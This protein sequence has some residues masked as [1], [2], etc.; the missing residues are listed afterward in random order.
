MPA[1][2]QALPSVV[3]PAL[4]GNVAIHKVWSRS[5]EPGM[6]R[7]IFPI[8]NWTFMGLAV[9]VLLPRLAVEL[10]LDL[11]I[12]DD[13][14]HLRPQTVGFIT[15][16]LFS[17]PRTE[18]SHS[19][20]STVRYSTS[21][22]SSGGIDLFHEHL[23]ADRQIGIQNHSRA[24]PSRIASGTAVVDKLG[25][26]RENFIG[27]PRL[28]GNYSNPHALNAQFPTA[29]GNHHVDLFETRICESSL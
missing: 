4:L 9:F 11:S 19:F 21:S 15:V 1:S 23:R 5:R 24:G 26:V 28:G 18:P 3:L 2:L 12:H 6:R 29:I 27:S 20:C 16:A 22:S 25:V 17:A 7:S 10:W 8:V 13:S 14:E